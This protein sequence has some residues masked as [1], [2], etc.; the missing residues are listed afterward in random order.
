VTIFCAKTAQVTG[1]GAATDA[2]G[3]GGV[4]DTG[5]VNNYGTDGAIALQSD[6]KIVVA[7]AD[8]A[9]WNFNVM[10]YE[11][12]GTPGPD[13]RLCWHTNGSFL[14]GGWRCGA[15]DFLNTS[16]AYERLIFEAP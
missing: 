12:N 8:D 5:I 2:F 15:N 7:A 1:K 10:R 11:T 14:V 6:G 9:A 4:V 13:L 3:T 16:T